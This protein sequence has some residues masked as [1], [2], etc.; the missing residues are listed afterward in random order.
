[1]SGESVALEDHIQRYKDLLQS[2]T[3]DAL[4][5]RLAI[6]SHASA[7]ASAI[8]DISFT[9]SS[10][11]ASLRSEMAAM[12]ARHGLGRRILAL[13]H[14][15]RTI[16]AICS[17]TRTDPLSFEEAQVVNGQINL[18]YLH[19]RGSLDNL[20]WAYL[21]EKEPEAAKKVPPQDISLFHLKTR[22]NLC[23]QRL[24]NDLSPFD[25]WVRKLATRRDPVVH[26]IPLYVVPSVLN[27]AEANRYRELGIRHSESL[28]AADLAAADEADNEQ[29][30]LGTF[31]SFFAHDPFAETY[32]IYPTIPADLGCLVRIHHIVVRH[33]TGGSPAQGAPEVLV[34]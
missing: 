31:G 33:V 4:A 27:E 14:A 20:A 15:Y 30:S 26:R 23:D 25:D 2:P 9:I 5:R 3:N 6:E 11:A 34:R 24:Q 8:L 10:F 18:F 16:R 12:H 1:M 13:E 17:V 32:P 28:F 29:R 22:K 21:L 7:V 19:L